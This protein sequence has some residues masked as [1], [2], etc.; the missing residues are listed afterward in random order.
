MSREAHVQFC[1]S[2]GVRFHGATHRN[3]Y[4]GSKRAG[5]RIMQAVTT[6]LEQR[7]KLKVNV[8]KSAVARP[9]E[10]MFLGYSMTWHKKPKLKIA[11]QSRER[12]AEKIRKTLQGARG[13]SLEQAIEPERVNEF[14]TSGMK[15]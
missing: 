9:W 8:S 12:L 11:Q 5:E 10:R 13:G 6:F 7:L 4:V 2:L 1:E 15:V 3:I 14:E